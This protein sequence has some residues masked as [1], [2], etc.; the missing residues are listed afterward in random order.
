MLIISTA[1]SAISINLQHACSDIVFLDIPK[2]ANLTLQAIGRVYRLRQREEVSVQVLA[3]NHS[4]NRV[5][6]CNAATKIQGQIAGQG[7]I[8]LSQEEE[9]LAGMGE[10]SKDVDE[11]E[12]WEQIKEDLTFQ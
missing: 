7:R 11:E 6:Q 3:L 1:T 10:T 9:L 8:E 5:I 2:N 4:Y 12:L